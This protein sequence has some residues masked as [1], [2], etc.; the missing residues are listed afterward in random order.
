MPEAMPA[1]P[2][3]PPPAP[4][5]AWRRRHGFPR[6]HGPIEHKVKTPWLML[7]CPSDPNRAAPRGSVPARTPAQR[8]KDRRNPRAAEIRAVVLPSRR[9]RAA[10]PQD[11]AWT[12]R[13]DAVKKPKEPKSR[14]NP[15]QTAVDG[16]SPACACFQPAS[17]PPH[18]PGGLAVPVGQW[19]IG[20]A[21]PNVPEK[22]KEPE[23]RRNPGKSGDHRG[24]DE[25]GAGSR[26][27][28]RCR[29][30]HHERLS[31]RAGAIWC[32]RRHGRLAGRARG[33]SHATAR[34]ASSVHPAALRLA[35]WRWRASCSWRR[36]PAPRIP[37]TIAMTATTTRRRRRS[38]PTRR[39]PTR[40]RIRTG[41]AGS[42]S[43][44][45]S[46]A[47]MLSN[48]YPPEFAV[49]AKGDAG[50]EAADRGDA[51]RRDRYHLSRPG[52]AWPC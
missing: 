28:A 2:P 41:P 17:G 32:R 11:L 1:P 52:A 39:A 30:W 10:A 23:S 51:G 25:P 13:S 9:A 15:R 45:S 35:R 26:P 21:R 16:A 14:R 19:R 6:S 33:G 18:G 40:S 48:P 7:R 36:R 5:P 24:T 44:S 34:D 37:P 47:Q 20:W 50:G 46:R 22:P 31:L 43:S 3:A 12:A 27:S 38:R 49:F 29:A 42:A 8:S 4:A